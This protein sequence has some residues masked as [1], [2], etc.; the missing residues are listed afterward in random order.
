VVVVVSVVVFMTGVIAWCCSLP[1]RLT[2]SWVLGLVGL[3]SM[4][5]CDGGLGHP[6]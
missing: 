6:C 4:D 5:S 2:P 3:K 1:V